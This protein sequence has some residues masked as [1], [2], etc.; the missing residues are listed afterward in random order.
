[1]LAMSGRAR[2]PART[3]GKAAVQGA[4]ATCRSVDIPGVPVSRFEHGTDSGSC[5]RLRGLGGPAAGSGTERTRLSIRDG[6][7]GS[8]RI[9]LQ[10]E[11]S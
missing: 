4:S 5:H 7:Y 11:T 3:S 9:P 2:P 10:K 6:G 8:S 1:M